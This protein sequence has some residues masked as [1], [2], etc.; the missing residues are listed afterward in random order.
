MEKSL[1]VFRFILTTMMCIMTAMDVIVI[2]LQVV[3]RFVL[4]VSLAWVSELAGVSLVWITFLGAS[5]AT[6]DESNI[7]FNGLIDKASGLTK[8]LLKLLVNCLILFMVYIMI[9]YGYKTM[10]IGLNTKMV[11]LP[12]TLAV[13]VSVIPISGVF[14]ALAVLLNIYK[15]F[16][17][18]RGL[19]SIGPDTAAIYDDVPEEVLEKANASIE[20]A[21]KE[22]AEKEETET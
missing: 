15:D 18:Y 12:T 2:V 1:K 10:R 22:V 19:G 17:V 13:C 16:R 8:F 4:H 9:R 6:L 14:M 21:D 3:F 7:N 11:A 20:D 5:L